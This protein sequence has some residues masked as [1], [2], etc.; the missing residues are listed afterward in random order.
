MSSCPI[1]LAPIKSLRS[2]TKER[3]NLEKGRFMPDELLKARIDA[4]VDEVWDDAVKDM[5]Y[6]IAVE[7]V[8]DLDHAAPDAPYGPASAE[9]LRR[10]LEISERLGLVPTNCNGH[11]GFSDLV[12]ESGT[13]IATIAHVDIVP[14]GLGWNYPPLEVTRDRGFLIG[15]GIQDDKGPYIL[16]LYAAHF[17]A[18]QVAETGKKL[19]YTLRCIAGCNEETG[20]ADVDWYLERYPAPAFCFTPDADF[21]LIC[22][23][24]GVYHGKF[25]SKPGLAGGALESIAGGTVPNAI[26]GR[27]EA[28]V[29]VAAD[30]LPAQEHIFLEALDGGRARIVATGK[31]GHA[32]LPAGTENAI[33]MLAGYLA[34]NIEL[35]DDQAVFFSLAK[36]AASASDGSALGIACADDKFGPLTAIGGTI[37][38][39]EDGSIAQTIDV[40]YPASI[41]GEE[42]TRR[43]AELAEAHG[44]SYELMDDAVPFYIEPTSPEISALLATYREY[45]GSREAPLVIGGG[46]YARH[47]PRACAFGPDEPLVANPAWVGGE[48]GPDEGIAEERLRCALKIYILSIARLMELDLS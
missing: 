22:G 2:Y 20:M 13:Q 9:A 34:A 18:R 35:T 5:A 26:P 48:H 42:I 46:T 8:E 38:T 28:V 16:S 14:L 15:R 4:Y 23:E 45:T 17:F 37:A 11:I 10:A 40:R 41:T 19:P 39:Q 21:P 30:T 12:G 7:S 33:D 6:L 44:A 24:K 31:G 43:M 3:N 25:T 1:I 29:A 47:F 36:A 32:S 27:A